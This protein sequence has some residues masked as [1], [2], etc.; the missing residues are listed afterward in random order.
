[1]HGDTHACVSP[2]RGFAASHTRSIRSARAEFAAVQ[3]VILGLPEDGLVG[4]YFREVV[5]GLEEK[6]D[7][8]CPKEGEFR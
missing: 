8:L 3:S 7:E 4:K 1:M 6:L 5:P 2:C